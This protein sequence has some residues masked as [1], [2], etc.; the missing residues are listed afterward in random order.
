M[1]SL[2]QGGIYRVRYGTKTS[3]STQRKGVRRIEVLEGPHTHERF[4]LKITQFESELSENRHSLL[5][6]EKG[7]KLNNDQ[8]IKNY[9]SYNYTLNEVGRAT[10]SSRNYPDERERD[11]I[12]EKRRC[13][14]VF[15][16]C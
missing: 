14:L 7:Q 1:A 8:F 10:E 9:K 16:E 2:V 5:E 12:A 13:V 15:V 4:V 11:K 3:S 6:R